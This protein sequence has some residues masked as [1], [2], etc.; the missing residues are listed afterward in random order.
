MRGWLVEQAQSP[1]LAG[2]VKTLPRD[3]EG[4]QHL[5]VWPLLC[6]SPRWWVS[7]LELGSVEAE[8]EEMLS[9]AACSAKPAPPLANAPGLSAEQQG[10]DQAL[11]KPSISPSHLSRGQ[12]GLS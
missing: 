2:T 3:G 1:R 9:G 8:C 11:V 7:G 10:P 4:H 6:G 12:Q 5:S